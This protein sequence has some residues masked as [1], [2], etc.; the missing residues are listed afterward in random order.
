MTRDWANWALAMNETRRHKCAPPLGDANLGSYFDS[1]SP[2]F[3]PSSKLALV[4]GRRYAVLARS[5]SHQ[6]FNARPAAV[7]GASP[8]N[9]LVSWGGL[10]RL[11]ARVRFLTRMRLELIRKAEACHR[12]GLS[13]R[14]A[15]LESEIAFHSSQIAIF[16]DALNKARVDQKLRVRPVHRVSTKSPRRRP[17]R[18]IS[19]TRK[20]KSPAR[21]R[22]SSA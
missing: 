13:M 6:S 9:G 17:M 8:D 7:S 3:P 19:R 20:S 12:H 10:T 1:S 14:A 5:S 18:R 16:V 22:D 15:H 21:M 4:D 11:R 2:L